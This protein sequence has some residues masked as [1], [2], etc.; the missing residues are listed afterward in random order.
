MPDEEIEA[1]EAKEVRTSHTSQTFVIHRS[2][3]YNI[4]VFIRLRKN[5]ESRVLAGQRHNRQSHHSALFLLIRLGRVPCR[6]D[7][8]VAVFVLVSPTTP[9]TIHRPRRSDGL[10]LLY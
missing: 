3:K 6:V 5:R 10:L 4:I 8:A 2:K 1:D 9:A 7:L